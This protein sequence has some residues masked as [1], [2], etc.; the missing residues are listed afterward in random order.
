MVELSVNF[1]GISCLNSVYVGIC[2][3]MIDYWPTRKQLLT[4]CNIYFPPWFI[5][6]IYD[7]HRFS[8]NKTYLWTINTLSAFKIHYLII[9]L[10]FQCLTI[11][12]G[13]SFYCLWHFYHV[14]HRND[15]ERLKIR[16]NYKSWGRRFHCK[17]MFKGCK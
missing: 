7:L 6:N 11:K 4:K 9:A 10:I 14:Y 8:V 16:V 3:R 17:V 2:F 13:K 12:P 15:L 5:L 1:C